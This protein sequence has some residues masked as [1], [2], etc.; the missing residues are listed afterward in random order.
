MKTE[1]EIIVELNKND[2]SAC[3]DP[4]FFHGWVEALLWVLK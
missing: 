4:N 2:L 3:S 1:E